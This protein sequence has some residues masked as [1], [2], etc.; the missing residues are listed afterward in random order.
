MSEDRGKPLPVPDLVSRDFWEGARE[1]RLLLQGCGSCGARQFYPRAL[2]VA[3]GSQELGWWPASGRGTI[4]SH[5]V[6]RR[7]QAPWW[8]AEL[9]YVVAMVELEEGPRLL[10]NIVGCPPEAVRI[11]M[12]V[13]VRFQL[14]RREEIRLPVFAPAPPGGEPTPT[15]TTRPSEA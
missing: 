3:C 7:H 14:T 15:R 8:E 10:T 9:P 4:F 11:G 6:I 5:T 2:C 1:G 13:E 12:P